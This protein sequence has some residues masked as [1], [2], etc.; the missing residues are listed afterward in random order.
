MSKDLI[1]IPRD[2]EDKKLVDEATEEGEVLRI[3]SA[4]AQG[5]GAR[6]RAYM[7]KVTCGVVKSNSLDIA[8]M[9]EDV[10]SPAVQRLVARYMHGAINTEDIR[11]SAL[12]LKCVLSLIS[13][14]G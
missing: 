13:I 9:A 6:A 12:N 4:Y 14:D 5:E 11:E 2:L 8:A 10:K 3:P 1:V 7:R